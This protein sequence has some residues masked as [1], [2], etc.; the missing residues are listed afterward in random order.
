MGRN[1]FLLV[2]AGFLT[3]MVLSCGGGGGD[4]STSSILTGQFID[5]PVAGLDYKTSSG[6]SGT[7]NSKGYFNYRKGDTV[8]FLIG[9]IILGDAKGD[10]VI[11]PTSLYIDEIKD[12][13]VL[14]NKA[15]TI[16]ALLLA[17]DTDPAD[18]VITIP[19]S[20]KKALENTTIDLE[21]TDQ[22]N[23]SA[24]IDG[25]GVEEDLDQLIQD[26]QGE[27]SQHYTDSLYQLAV[28]SLQS[29]DG[30]TVYFLNYTDNLASC[31][32]C[33]L[34]FNEEAGTIT[35]SN[36][37]NPESNG[38]NTLEK[39][40]TGVNLI[41]S[42]GDVL[43][44][45]IADSGKICILDVDDGKTY[46]A[47][48]GNPPSDCRSDISDTPPEDLRDLVYGKVINGSLTPDTKVRIVPD[49]NWQGDYD[50]I[51]CSV[52]PSNGEFGPACKLYTDRNLFKTSQQCQVIVFEDLNDSWKFEKEEE[53]TVKFGADIS[54]SIISNFIIDIGNNSAYPADSGIQTGAVSITDFEDFVTAANNKNIY[55]LAGEFQIRQ[56]SADT[57]NKLIRFSEFTF[58][59]YT[60]PAFT[61]TY[62][63]ENGTVYVRDINGSPDVKNPATF[64]YQDKILCIEE[65]GVVSDT[66]YIHS[67]IVNPSQTPIV[68]QG[69]STVENTI[70][71]TWIEYRLSGEQGLCLRFEN[72]T[73]YFYEYSTGQ[74]GST[75]YNTQSVT[76]NG[77]TITAVVINTGEEDINIFP[78]FY[79]GNSIYYYIMWFDA[80]T[81]NLKD[82]ALRKL[83]PTSTCP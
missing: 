78:L 66:S 21:S 5:A 39:T 2:P 71:G 14:Q 25:D 59:N 17:F 27:A 33:T 46:C 83:V 60:E 37:Q 52:N 69:A 81:E 4:S 79:D 74:S 1:S 29:L 6:I 9:G 40:P 65:Y 63:E 67:C 43:P 55:L 64:K 35:F 45:V 70:E 75:S 58:D 62:W 48:K 49:A 24:D 44:V 10:S 22:L 56:L 77:R 8:E 11:T 31:N 82:A 73:V 15:L 47:V 26:K 68:E 53:Y 51:V 12:P 28:D 32:T 36:C 80:N 61:L 3:A 20:V 54:C 34:S 16:S 57:T 42:D 41:D 72:G 19:D 23:I 13:V 50:G 76:I 7:T 38:T 30:N 18:G